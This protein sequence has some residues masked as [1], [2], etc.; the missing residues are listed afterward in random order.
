M[1][2]A[3]IDFET[4]NHRSD[5]P[6]QVAVVLVEDGQ[7]VSE[8]SWLIRPRDMYFSDRCIAVHGIFPSDVKNEPEWDAVWDELHPMIEGRVLIAHNAMFDMAVLNAT[9]ATY[10][11]A[12]PKIE[13]Q[14]TRLIARRT[15]PGRMGYGL[16]PT[17][18]MLGLKFQHHVAVEDA[19]TCAEVAL[20]AAR[21]ANASSL[22]ALER[23]LYIHRGFVEGKKRVG[24]KT[25]R[26]PKSAKAAL[27]MPI[28]AIAS[29]GEEIRPLA[30]KR[31]FLQG[32]LLGMERDQAVEFLQRLGAQVEQDSNCSAD[33]W[34]IGTGEVD[35]TNR[36]K[37]NASLVSEPHIDFKAGPSKD[38]KST[39]H[40]KVTRILSQ[41][42]FLA[43][44][45]G[46]LELV[47]KFVDTTA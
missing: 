10:D 7:I 3:A 31:I 37:S 43:M 29:L 11:L 34:L 27:Q 42:Q 45:P 40:T 28:E 8:R 20:A 2:F 36:S 15:W 5:S 9:L 19:R 46:G 32:Q 44:I 30:G 17:A 26:R 12:C 13:F 38:S 18:D 33:F 35:S 23:E 6:C 4:A 25:I 47:R 1:S 39:Q 22:V 16:K 14:C 21:T 24:P 41:R